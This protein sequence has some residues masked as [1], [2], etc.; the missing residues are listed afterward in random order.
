MKRKKILVEC[1]HGIGDLVMTFPAVLKIK[2]IHPYAEIHMLVRNEQ[3]GDFVKNIG[4]A[5]EYYEL[6]VT[7]ENITKIFSV[8]YCICFWTI[9][10]RVGCF[11]VKTWW[12]S[13]SDF[14]KT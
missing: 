5:E 9:T 11:I 8:L 6:D 1:H 4:L 7:G 3:Q 13:K 12:V 14:N 10:K 2:E